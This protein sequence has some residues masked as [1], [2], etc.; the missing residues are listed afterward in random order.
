MIFPCCNVAKVNLDVAGVIFFNVA[1]VAFE[2]CEFL[3]HVA[4]NMVKCCDKTFSTF[5]FLVLQ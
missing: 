2:C 4:C 5:L 3:N 1:D